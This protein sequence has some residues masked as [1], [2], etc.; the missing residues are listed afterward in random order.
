MSLSWYFTS[1]VKVLSGERESI[2]FWNPTNNVTAPYNGPKGQ[3]RS[4]MPNKEPRHC[5]AVRMVIRSVLGSTSVRPASGAVLSRLLKSSATLEMLLHNHK[6]ALCP[7]AVCINQGLLQV[8]T[9]LWYASSRLVFHLRC[10]CTFASLRL[11][12]VPEGQADQTRVPNALLPRGLSRGRHGLPHC[13]LS[14]LHRYAHYWGGISIAAVSH[15]I[16][17]VLFFHCV[18][19]LSRPQLRWHVSWQIFLKVCGRF[20]LK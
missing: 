6:S 16:S 19:I 13:D 10:V 2:R 15:Q 5:H 3:R 8:F 9:S 12:A 1:C 20:P 14:H 7:G 18:L 11:P 17:C 4:K